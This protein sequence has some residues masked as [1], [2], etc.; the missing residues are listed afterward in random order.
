MT[1]DEIDR[2]V[3]RLGFAVVV[4]PEEMATAEAAIRHLTDK[5]AE[6]GKLASEL[7]EAAV[8]CA[9]KRERLGSTFNGRGTA[10]P[11]AVVPGVDGIIGIEGRSVPGIPWDSPSGPKAL[12]IWLILAAADRPGDRMRVLEQLAKAAR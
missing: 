11:H 10:L 2:L 7:V 12:R 5:L 9:L 4:L 1:N 8:E 3:E 6:T